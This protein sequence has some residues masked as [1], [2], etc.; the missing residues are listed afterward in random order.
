MHA[1]PPD[2]TF[3]IQKR[4]EACITFFS[5]PPTRR[6]GSCWDLQAW[7]HPCRSECAE[8]S[9]CIKCPS[10]FEKNCDNKPRLVF[11]QEVLTYLH[12]IVKGKNHQVNLTPST[13]TVSTS[14]WSPISPQRREEGSAPI[15][16]SDAR[17]WALCIISRMSYMSGLHLNHSAKAHT[18]AKKVHF[19][20]FQSC[21]R[22]WSK[23]QAT[24]RIA[25]LAF[26]ASTS[27]SLSFYVLVFSLLLHLLFLLL[28]PFLLFL[29]LFLPLLFLL[30]F[31]WMNVFP[32]SK[33]LPPR[34][35]TTD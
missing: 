24:L 8:A 18:N 4:W 35:W 16:F 10:D 23:R 3:W 32:H 21:K 13:G 34:D 28:L 20:R 29:L 6:S 7:C 14:C 15:E 2:Q 17:G 12:D 26:A 25:S 22:L 11:F 19:L 9:S 33:K 1:R 5:A 31:E 30:H 27:V